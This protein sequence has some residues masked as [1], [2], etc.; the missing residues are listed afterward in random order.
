MT[1]SLNQPPPL[2][3]IS[4][5]GSATEDFCQVQEII[6]NSL[7]AFLK[8][9]DDVNSNAKEIALPTTINVNLHGNV[10][11]AGTSFFNKTTSCCFYSL[12]QI[13]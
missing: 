4:R 3:F 11:S 6:V 2:P 9:S 5:P 7:G 12:N 1:A 13:R 10:Y 8:T